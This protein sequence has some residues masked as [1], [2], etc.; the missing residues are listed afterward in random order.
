VA[1]PLAV[2]RGGLRRIPYSRKR[3]ILVPADTQDLAAS[4]ALIPPY[5]WL[6][7]TRDA[8]PRSAWSRRLATI[9]GA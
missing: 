4:D 1:S 5:G 6:N 7:L 2:R 8:G 9:E 3:V